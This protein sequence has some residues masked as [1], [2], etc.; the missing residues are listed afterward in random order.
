VA[1]LQLSSDV[2]FM[3]HDWNIPEKYAV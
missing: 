2:L 1:S 3:F